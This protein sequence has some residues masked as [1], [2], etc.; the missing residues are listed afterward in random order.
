MLDA[1]VCIHLVR[2][3]ATR[4]LDRFRSAGSAVA[5][6]T[7]VETELRVGVAKSPEPAKAAERVERLLARTQVLPFDQRA[8]AHAADIRAELEIAGTKIGAYEGLIAG[9]ARSLGLTLVT[10]N[11]REFS[12]VPGL[13]RQ[14]WFAE[15]DE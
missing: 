10:S 3:R 12:R 8:A 15:T 7:V 4:S 9:H 1:D 5:V 11:T 2:R 14:D 6:S 13:L